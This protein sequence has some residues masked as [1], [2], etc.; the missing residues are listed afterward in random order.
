MLRCA[1]DSNKQYDQGCYWTPRGKFILL[2]FI[3]ASQFEP[4]RHARMLTIST[5]SVTLSCTHAVGHVLWEQLGSCVPSNSW[6]INSTRIPDYHYDYGI[7]LQ[8]SFRFCQFVLALPGYC[9]MIINNLFPVVRTQCYCYA[10][11]TCIA[12]LWSQTV[13]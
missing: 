5:I 8:T 11:P 7:L 3:K 10:P 6:N 1:N 2:F 9:W 13:F 4:S 12:I